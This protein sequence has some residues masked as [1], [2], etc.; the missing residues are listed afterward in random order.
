MNINSSTRIISYFNTFKYLIKIYLIFNIKK[1]ELLIHYLILNIKI[2]KNQ[3]DY[4]IKI[5]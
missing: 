1:P 4:K 3:K 5:K 2:N